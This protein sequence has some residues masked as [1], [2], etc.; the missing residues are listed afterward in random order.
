M[1]IP[2]SF[3][4]KPS[5]PSAKQ[6]MAFGQGL[7]EGTSGQE[8]SFTIDPKDQFSNQADVSGHLD[9][10][11]ATSQLINNEEGTGYGNSF[12]PVLISY[13][14]H[15]TL[16]AVYTPIRSGV[17]QLNVTLN[18]SHIF[19]SPFLVD[20][21]PASTFAWSTFSASSLF[22]CFIIFSPA[23]AGVF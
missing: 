12:I 2:F 5:H 4:V 11:Q 9:D 18:G 14:D 8:H 6:T 13:N 17:Y 19:G 22:I 16:D 1:N 10:F 3:Q 15:K 20:T 21:S 7:Y 23:M